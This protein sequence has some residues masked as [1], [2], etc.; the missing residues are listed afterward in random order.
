MDFGDFP[1]GYLFHP[2][3]EAKDEIYKAFSLSATE[4]AQGAVWDEEA[5]HIV[6]LQGK[7]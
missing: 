7:E 4:A 6:T 2:F 1:D 5:K 3:L